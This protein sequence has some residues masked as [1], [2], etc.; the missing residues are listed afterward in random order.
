MDCERAGKILKELALSGA[1][2]ANSPELAAHVS[3]CAVCREAFASEQAFVAAMNR[4]VAAAIAGEPSPALRVR[5]RDQLAAPARG[6]EWRWAAVA[7]VSLLAFA[8]SL[9]AVHSRRAQPEKSISS[10]GGE[11]AAVAPVAAPVSLSPA[12]TTRTA[13]LLRRKHVERERVALPNLPAVLIEKGEREAMLCLLDDVRSGRLD[14]ESLLTQ[15]E[16]IA[17]AKLEISPL[18]LPPLAEKDSSPSD[19]GTP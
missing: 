5:V 13:K 4:G 15:Q 2:A 3:A 7:A 11:T 19:S 1:T 17:V 12:A 8:I 9:R 18:K 14:A 16:P 10:P 6:W